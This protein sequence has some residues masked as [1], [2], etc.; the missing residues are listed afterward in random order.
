MVVDNVSLKIWPSLTFV[1]ICTYIVQSLENRPYLYIHMYICT[2]F[3]HAFLSCGMPGANTPLTINNVAP[4][5]AYE[6]HLPRCWCGLCDDDDVTVAATY[7]N[8]PRP[9]GERL[10]IN[11]RT[12]TVKRTQLATLWFI[13][14]ITSI[15][16]MGSKRSNP[17]LHCAIR[18]L[19]V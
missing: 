7:H 2:L 1:D 10:A 19:L 11:K 8:S 4:Y 3:L 15:C 17:R 14:G 18:R 6:N 16:E 12:P 5:G 9:R 13:G